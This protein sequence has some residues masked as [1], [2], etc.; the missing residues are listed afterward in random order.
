MNETMSADPPAGGE[1]GA[2]ARLAGVFFSPAKTFESIGRKPGR[3]WVVPVLLLMLGVFVYQSIAGPKI[4]VDEAV[5]Q[6]LRVTE[7]M[8]GR[9]LPAEQREEIEQGIRQQ[10]EGQNSPARR[11]LTLP[12]IL[13]PIF[14]VPALYHAI[15]A[16]TGRKSTYMRL[17]SAYSYTQTIQLVPL[18]LSSLVA[19]LTTHK[20]SVNDV[21]FSRVLKSNAAAWLDFDSTHKAVLALLSSVDVF[22]IWAFVVGTIA[23]S[24]VTRFS[25]R[26][27][28]LTVG[29]VWAAYI[30]LKIVLGVVYQTFA[31]S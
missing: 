22:D 14:L 6:Q 20:L 1:P 9:E 19:A 5:A 3:D 26:G 11:A 24:R 29:G 2:L 28:A 23:L 4:D 15:A 27:A 16:A 31:F 7:K 17:V 12:F 25:V 30:L 13:I 10:V 21:Q 8:M 18:L